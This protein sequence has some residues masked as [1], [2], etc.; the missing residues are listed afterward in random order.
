[1]LI[2]MDRLCKF[3][4]N[5]F[6][7]LLIISSTIARKSNCTYMPIFSGYRTDTFGF[8]IRKEHSCQEGQRSKLYAAIQF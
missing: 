2:D 1:M 4:N 3:Q 8:L 6:V 5:Q 7:I